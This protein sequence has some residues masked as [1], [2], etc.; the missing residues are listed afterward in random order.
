MGWDPRGEFLGIP[1]VGGIAIIQTRLWQKAYTLR[2]NVHW[3]KLFI[4]REYL[5]ISEPFITIG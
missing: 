4:N 3:N 1:T 5:L 2:S